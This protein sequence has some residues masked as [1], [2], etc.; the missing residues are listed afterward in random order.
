M[1]FKEL[2]EA[3]K[4]KAE[5]FIYDQGNGYLFPI[6][7]KLNIKGY[8]EFMKLQRSSLD[9]NEEA[10]KINKM[11]IKDAKVYLDYLMSYDDITVASHFNVSRW[12]PENKVTRG[13][14]IG[15]KVTIKDVQGL[16]NVGYDHDSDGYMLNRKTDNLL[17]PKEIGQ[18][19][20]AAKLA[21]GHKNDYEVIDKFG[22]RKFNTHAL[23]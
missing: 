18:T 13:K 4:Q 9:N 12:H 5:A 20:K 14:I 7:I 22:G 6:G 21:D 11:T 3:K 17:S 15:K 1:R 2:F 23:A 19:I 8:P 16:H 10:A